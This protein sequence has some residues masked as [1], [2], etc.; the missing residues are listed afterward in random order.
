MKK[1]LLT[2]IILI[3]L[4]LTV[5]AQ[6]PKYI[7]LFIGDG[8]GF[9]HIALTEA[10]L[11]AKNDSIGFRQLNF[12]KFPSVGF[13]TTNAANRLTTCSAAAGT[14]LATANKTSINTIGMNADRS[15]DLLSVAAKAKAK[16]LK[17]GVT[18]SVS[19]DHATPAAFFSH[20]PNRQM[21]YQISEWLTKS[22]FDLYAGS[23]MLKPTEG[24]SIYDIL[25]ENSYTIVKGAGQEL[26]GEKIYWEQATGSNPDALPLAIES[27]AGEL[28]L[29]EIT[30][31]SIN[32]LKNKRG[33]FLMV[34]GGQIDWAA[35]ANDAA[36]IVHEVKDFDNAITKAI[37]F[38][39]QN[40]KETL[41]VITADHETGGL[42]LG[43]D[44][45]GYDTDLKLLFNQKVSKG[46]LEKLIKTSEN[47]QQAK[48]I[49]RSNLGFWDD[50]KLTAKEELELCVAFENKKEKCAA[51]AIKLLNTKAGV[52]FTTGSHTAAYV[53]IFAIGVGAEKFR[54]YMDN[55]DIPKQIENLI[56]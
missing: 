56:K 45:R 13:A 11:A 29:S 39:N 1:I 53:P 33:F 16:G 19:I 6:N 20:A 3:A 42:A 35:H 12:T 50:V 49:L 30:A 36:S 31:K 22:G 28:T 41:I 23:G 7:F 5:C 38:Y 51:L 44:S 14:A 40:P 15:Q 2:T 55:I 43:T 24:K 27:K 21:S 34:E 17:V 10:S 25:T 54:G 47:W 18:T 8:M 37:E 32:F 26:Q 48:D 4:Q 9:N 46:T 52:D